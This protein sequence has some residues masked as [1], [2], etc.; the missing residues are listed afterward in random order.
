MSRGSSTPTRQINQ[1]VDPE[2]VQMLQGNCFNA[3]YLQLGKR[4]M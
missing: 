4:Q 3:L 1:P 2:T